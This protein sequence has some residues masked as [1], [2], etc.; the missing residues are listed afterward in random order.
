MAA[1]HFRKFNHTL[2]FDR[3]LPQNILKKICY[4]STVF[5]LGFWIRSYKVR[6]SRD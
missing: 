4:T 1:K 5:R 6:Q 2:E 3:F